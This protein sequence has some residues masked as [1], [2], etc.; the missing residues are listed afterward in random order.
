MIEVQI[1]FRE[2]DV[3]DYIFARI[4]TPLNV[5]KSI[6]IPCPS[7]LQTHSPKKKFY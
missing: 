7:I 6:P 1:I 4:L 5:E 2:M 3:I